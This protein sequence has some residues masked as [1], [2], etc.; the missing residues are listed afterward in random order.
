MLKDLF[1]SS[2]YCTFPKKTNKTL[3]L[4]ERIANG[5]FSLI[6]PNACKGCRFVCADN[7]DDREQLR[8]HSNQSVNIISIDQVFSF[9]QNPEGPICDYMIDSRN[10]VIF[11]EMTCTTTDYIVSKR[12]K[13]RNQLYNT[14]ILLCANPTLKQHIERKETRY[15]VFSWKETYSDYSEDDKVAANMKGM[16]LLSDEVYS[17]NNESEFINGFKIKEI[18]YPH[19]LDC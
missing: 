5:D 2:F 3:I 1:E 17:P 11:V 13:A 18:R 15:V 9:L 10:S 16:T 7:S 6:D 14:L 19:V 4:E 8:I 12:Q